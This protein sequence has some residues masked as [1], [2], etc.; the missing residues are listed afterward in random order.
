[1]QCSSVRFGDYD[2][3]GDLDI[4]LTGYAGSGRIAK[5][6]RNTG[7]SFAEDSCITLP[8]IFYSSIAF[9]DFDNEGDLDILISG[10]SASGK[11]AKVYRNTGGS[12]NEDTGTLLPGVNLSSV[13]FGDYDNDG[14]LDL[15]ISGNTSSNDKIAKVYKNNGS[16]FIEDAGINLPGVEYG[17]VDFGDYDNDGDLDILISGDD[18]NNLITKMYQNN[19]GSFAEDTGISLPGIKES[20]VEFGDY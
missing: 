11:I 20:S 14:D 19:S 3:D 7:G 1:M 17:S 5:V 2:N 15:V 18:G 13:A 10:D 9:G 4:L 12:F 6:Y 8:G 16:T